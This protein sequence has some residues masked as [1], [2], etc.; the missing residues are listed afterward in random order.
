MDLVSQRVSHRTFYC[1][2]HMAPSTQTNE[3]INYPSKITKKARVV[4]SNESKVN[5]MPLHQ[6]ESLTRVYLS[7]TYLIRFGRRKATETEEE[8]RRGQDEGWESLTT[9]E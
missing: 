9:E 3:G 2:V 5:A 8:K 6:I 4:F 1:T 7:A